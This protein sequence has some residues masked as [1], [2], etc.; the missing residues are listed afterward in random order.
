MKIGRLEVPKPRIPSLLWLAEWKM[1]APLNLLH[2]SGGDGQDPKAGVRTQQ[3]VH[4]KKD[5]PFNYKEVGT[6][7]FNSTFNR[8]FLWM[9]RSHYNV[10][11][12]KMQPMKSSNI[13]SR[14]AKGLMAWT[15]DG[16]RE[17][18]RGA[19]SGGNFGSFGRTMRHPSRSEQIV[20]NNINT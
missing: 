8:L 15:Q 10:P 12:S 4:K 19:E 7:Y 17:S 11:F 14:K 20:W 13:G 9:F 2:C 18:K 1:S 3:W 5:K 6:H 16:Q